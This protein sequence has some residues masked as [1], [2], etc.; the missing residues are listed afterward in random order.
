M[1]NTQKTGFRCQPPRSVKPTIQ[2]PGNSQTLTW[3]GGSYMGRREG[4]G[5]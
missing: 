1:K 5:S 2:P 3:T 4:N